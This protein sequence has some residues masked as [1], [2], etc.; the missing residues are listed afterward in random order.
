MPRIEPVRRED[1]AAEYLPLYDEMAAGRPV[2]TGPYR[3]LMHTPEVALP[4]RRWIEDT[5]R[6][7]LQMPLAMMELAVLT[8]ARE[9][10]SEYVWGA[11]QRAAERAGTRTEAVAVVRGEAPASTLTPDEATV[12]SYAEQLAR[13]GRVDDATFDALKAR[14]GENDVIRL[15][16]IIGCYRLVSTLLGAFEVTPESEGQVNTFPKGG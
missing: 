2:T 1:V 6:G 16:T 14:W 10:R 12:M 3:I 8:V 4:W 13:T 11:H 9:E 5:L 15:T 7:G